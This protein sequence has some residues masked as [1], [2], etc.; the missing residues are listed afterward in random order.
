MAQP[1]VTAQKAKEAIETLRET[2]DDLL[3]EL[4]SVKDPFVKYL[5]A[6]TLKAK[7]QPDGPKEVHSARGTI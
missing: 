2:P 7:E 1:K 3:I 4:R 6:A 5:A